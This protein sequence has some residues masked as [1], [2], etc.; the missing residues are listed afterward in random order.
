VSDDALA[1]LI[2]CAPLSVVLVVLILM[3]LND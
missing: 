2:I 3:Y 1:V